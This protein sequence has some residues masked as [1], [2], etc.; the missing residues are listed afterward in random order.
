MWNFI[1][2]SGSEVP[3]GHKGEGIQEQLGICMRAQGSGHSCTHVYLGGTVLA[4]RHCSNSQDWIR[5][6]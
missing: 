6:L 1:C 4:P 5:S 3:M 2:W